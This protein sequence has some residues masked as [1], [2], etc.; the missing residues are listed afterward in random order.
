MKVAL[1]WLV[2]ALAGCGSPAANDA[3]RD[4]GPNSHLTFPDT[5]PSFD[6]ADTET[7]DSGPGIPPD[8]GPT[9]AGAEDAGTT[10]TGPVDAGP[11]DAGPVDTGPPVPCAAAGEACN[12]NN[13]CTVND[14]CVGG[15]CTGT[16]VECA[17]A[18]TCTTDQCVNG[19]CQH[20]VANGFCLVSGVCYNSG[21][22]NPADACQICS[23]QSTTAW[24]ISNGPC[25]DGNPCTGPDFCSQGGC[26]AGALT[27]FDKDG[28][29]P[30]V[31]GGLDCDD[32]SNLVASGKVEACADGLDNNCDGA[33]DADDINCG[34]G[35]KT[36]T[37]HVDC[38]PDAVCALWNSTGQKVCSQQCAGTSDCTGG[39]VCTRLPGGAHI[40]YCAPGFTNGK[41]TGEACTAANQCLEGLCIDDQCA[42]MCTNAQHCTKPGH[43]CGWIGNETVGLF[44][45]CLPNQPNARLNGQPCTV[46][47]ESYTGQVCMSGVC[48]L[49]LNDPATWT[50]SPVCTSEYGCQPAQECNLMVYSTVS[51]QTALPYHPQYTQLTNDAVTGCYS[52]ATG[53]GFLQ[54]GQSCGGNSQCK[55]N[56]C[57][58]LLPNDPTLYC[59]SLCSYDAECLPGLNCVLEAFTLTSDYLA[60]P[61]NGSQ[62]P[63][64]NSRSLVQVCKP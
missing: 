61:L 30:L 58:P 44:T 7:P 57:L 41:Q 16:Q 28:Q 51:N 33:T 47:N 45:A 13:A 4:T 31:C 9:D 1:P 3:A 62:P 54:D 48:D 22:A 49:A 11:V 10:D 5:T 34:G 63:A 25:E 20:P 60:D 50:C 43:T 23:A 42:Q 24:S 40:G 21:D 64:N 27:D 37:Y 35:V 32:N 36:C 8:S 18:V 39:L 55:S 26:V 56:K 12:D 52:V 53:A 59:T 6:V 38:H 2:I 19:T 14:Q 17:D 15:V 46:D 29:A